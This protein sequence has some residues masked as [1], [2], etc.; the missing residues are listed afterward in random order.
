MMIEF[1][2]FIFTT[3]PLVNY[4][5]EINQTN[6]KESKKLKNTKI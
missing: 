6:F 2:G 4:F 5:E 3:K 1:I